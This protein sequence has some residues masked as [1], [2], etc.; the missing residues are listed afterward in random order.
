VT[1]APDELALADADST[2]GQLQRGRG[3]GWLAAARSADAEELL[4]SCLE[5]DTCWDLQLDHRGDYYALL[6]LD[7][8]LT[9]DDLGPRELVYSHGRRHVATA[10]AVCD[11]TFA[12]TYAV[13]CLW[14]CGETRLIAAKAADASNEL[15]P[16]P[17]DQARRR[18]VRQRG[19]PQR[20]SRT[21]AT[22]P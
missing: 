9:V 12:S 20:G 15:A 8:G 6:A 18:P 14:G 13:E 7:I 22:T 19:D 3:V 1:S 17:T 10:L 4:R 11:P 5:R 16:K 2:L 21:T